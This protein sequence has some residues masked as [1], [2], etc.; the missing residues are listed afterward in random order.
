MDDQPPSQSPRMKWVLPAT[1]MIGAVV[2]LGLFVFLKN[3]GQKDAGTETRKL[4]REQSLELLDMRDRA[5]GYLENHAFAHAEMLLLEIIRQ[6]PDDPF[7]HRNLAICRELAVDVIDRQD[8]EGRKRQL[9]KA[10][11]AADEDSR[12]EPKSAAPHVLLARLAEREEDLERAA[13]ELR[14]ATELAPQSAAVWYDLFVLKPIAPGETPEPETVEALRK[15]RELE[16]GN[17]FVLKD[18]LPLQAQLKEPGFADTVKLARENL[19]PFA[20]VIKVNIRV[21]IRELLN[22]LEKAVTDQQWP[23]V[24]SVSISL[25]N[26]IAPESAR[27]ERY[28]RWNSLEYVLLDFESAFYDRADLPQESPTDSIPVKFVAGPNPITIPANVRNLATADFD[29]DGRLDGVALLE[30]QVVMTLPLSPKGDENVT[31]ISLDLTEGFTGVVP[32]DLDGDEDKKLKITPLK[33]ALA[34][35]DLIIFGPAGLKLLENRLAPD[36]LKRELVERPGADGLATLRDVQAIVP[37]DLDLDGDLDFVT[38][39][40]SNVQ[41]WSNRGNWTFDEITSRSKFPAAEF[42]P[43]AAVAVDWDRDTDVDLLLAGTQGFA[44]LENI[45]HGR[46]RWRDLGT[47]FAKAKGA[48][49]LLVEDFGNG[50]WSVVAAGNNGVDLIPTQT[51]RTGIVTANGSVRVADGPAQFAATLDFNNDGH[52][53][54]LSVSQ[55]KAAL[56]RGLS[57]G[58]FEPLSVEATGDL[59]NITVTAVADIDNDGDE[60]LLLGSSAETAWRANE[61]GNA[62]GWL[63]VTLIAEQIK[64]GEQN[65]SK[66]VNH[67]GIGSTIEVK[68]GRKY[69]A[70]VVRGG[71]THF[72]LGSGKAA[73]VMRVLWTNGIPQNL[74]EPT[75]NQSV[76]EELKLHGSCPYLYSWDG[77]KFAFCTDLLWNAPL[78]LKFAEDVVAPWREWEYLKIDGER[79]KP[80]NGEYQLRVTAELWEIE[81]FDQIKLFTVDHPVGTEIYTNEKVGPASMAE[82]KIHTVADPRPPVAARDTFGHDILDQ[83]KTRDGVY[84][85]TYERKIAQGLTTDHFLELDLGGWEHGAT[86]PQVTLFLTGWMYPGSTSLS[87]QHSQNPQQ[88]RQRPPALRAVDAQGQWHE[89]RPFMGFPGGKTK[90]IAVDISDVFGPDAKDHRVRIV[91][92][93]EFYWDA[94]F[95]TVN[96]RPVEFQQTEVPLVI[97]NLNNRRG[98]SF[99]QWPAS[100]NGPELFDFDQLVPG[101][102]WPPIEGK[103]TRFGDVHPLLIARDDHMVVMHPGD[104]IQ[105]SFAVPAEP[106]REGWVR[107][108]VIY[109]VGWD[110]DCDQN[111]VYGETSEP[112]PFGAMTV[113]P[114]RDGEPRPVDAEYSQYLKTYQTRTRDRSPFWNQVRRHQ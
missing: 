87:V 100:G 79:L 33:N 98:V 13:A 32:A 8:A 14:R 71:M 5:V 110:K 52:R 69:L 112:L 18:W 108:F 106:V 103:F 85:R 58:K 81:Y 27:D 89:V 34:D 91:T 15:V 105:L 6:V 43:T 60:D 76:Y 44:L 57:G 80:R 42:G 45:R 104:E 97:A 16:P 2:V 66:R 47:D 46:F 88:S 51:S 39:T 28:V 26:V 107:D 84:T 9:L 95:I 1:L 75:P 72:G 3:G 64:P 62:N 19:E 114:F 24:T 109:N 99:R 68:S 38:I 67:Y 12:I 29:L 7:G 20:D 40:P 65:Y 36:G 35:P 11:E 54:L 49:V 41:M 53:D 92:N 50:S 77:E 4:S 102:A 113:Y 56:W 83:V 31:T 10:R 101:E 73:S 61:G 17:L 25:R 111:T 82:H 55:G 96:D 90:T 22:R 30:K 23:T 70:Q 48:S 78:G 94:A 37:A 86:P 59:A 93:M 63:N 74:I 21:D